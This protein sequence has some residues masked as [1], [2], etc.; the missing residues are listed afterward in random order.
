MGEVR[1]GEVNTLDLLTSLYLTIQLLD[2]NL[3]LH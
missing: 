1:C 3:N 2:I